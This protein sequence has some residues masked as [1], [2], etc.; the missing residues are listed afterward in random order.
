MVP[1]TWDV[2]IFHENIPIFHVFK[3]PEF[4]F[5]CVGR[6]EAAAAAALRGV[7]GALAAAR[8]DDG[9]RRRAG[10]PNGYAQLGCGCGSAGIG[11]Y[12]KDSKRTVE[13][14]LFF[15]SEVGIVKQDIISISYESR[16]RVVKCSTQ[17]NRQW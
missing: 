6:P 15:F 9:P 10:G 7:Q 1:G 2:S 3:H 5:R 8:G 4:P 11:R 16:D 17:T 12:P 13:Y 14:V